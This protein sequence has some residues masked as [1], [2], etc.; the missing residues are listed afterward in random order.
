[1]R[2]YGE[3]VDGYRSWPN[4]K[5]SIDILLEGLIITTENFIHERRSVGWDL[6]PD[7]PKTMQVCCPLLSDDTYNGP[8]NCVYCFNGCKLWNAADTAFSI[9]TRCSLQ[10]HIPSVCY[11]NAC[12]VHLLLF[13][14]CDQQ[15]RNF[16]TNY[17]TP[18]CFDTIASS[19]G[20]M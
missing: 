6:N 13:M 5:Y 11:F 15:M 16:Y 9:L 1:M 4:L 10:E 2:K 20:R 12:T 3:N 18:A 17:H 19:S 14:Y 7:L 8:Y